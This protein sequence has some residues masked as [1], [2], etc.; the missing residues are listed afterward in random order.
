MFFGFN[1]DYWGPNLYKSLFLCGCIVNVVVSTQ[2]ILSVEAK[3]KNVNN[4]YVLAGP[5][6]TF[7]KDLRRDALGFPVIK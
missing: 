1:R 2:L 4:N 7:R 3:T 5:L 6:A